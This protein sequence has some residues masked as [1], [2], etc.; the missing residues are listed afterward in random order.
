GS[1]SIHIV[2]T[3]ARLRDSPDAAIRRLAGDADADVLASP[4]VRALLEFPLEVHP[5]KKWWG[6][7]WRLVALADLGV[8]PGAP[9]I[10]SGVDRELGWLTSTAHTRSIPRIDGLVR[11][12]AS[13]EGNAVYSSAK[14]GFA[15]DP[16]V[17]TLVESLLEWQ[18]PDG[19][20]NCDKEASGRRSSFHE[21]ITPALG[22]AAYHDAIGNDD[23]LKS[24]MRSAEL[25]L[26]HDLFKSTRTGKPVHPSWTMPHYPAYWHYD[27]L[28]GLRLLAAVEMLDDPR[29]G[30]ALDLVEGSRQRD[31]R[32][33]GPA[34]F[35]DR[36]RDAVDWGRGPENE[37]LNL[38]TEMILR[39]AGRS[40]G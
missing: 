21:T 13:M 29:G 15:S 27:I 4:R 3:I 20:W 22:L 1:V 6:T 30:D 5:Y 12:C 40:S 11:M 26:E 23:A 25:L 10:A 9:G 19:G 33:S 37:M 36:M 2:T 16:R 18:W 28:Q 31:G 32:F 7:H 34:W 14:L 38:L 8:P 17:A 35:S 24:A 39:A